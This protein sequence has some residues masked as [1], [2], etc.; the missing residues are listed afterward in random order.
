MGAGWKQWVTVGL[1]CAM[2]QTALGA[3]DDSAC[4]SLLH[5][6]RFGTPH[7][8][9]IGMAQLATTV[10]A[11]DS[12]RALILDAVR[13]AA[14]ARVEL[15]IFPELV[16]SGY[17]PRDWV[18]RPEFIQKNQ[19]SLDAIAAEVAAIPHAPQVLYLGSM[20][21][22]P[23]PQGRALQ[24]SAVRLAAGRIADIQAKSL[25]PTMD[26]FDE[27]RHFE[28]GSG[29]HL[30]QMASDVQL[31]C[32]ICEDA[33][34][35]PANGERS[36]YQRDLARELEQA[37]LIVNLSASPFFRGKVTLRDQVVGG[38]AARAHA[39]LVYVNAI[40]VH[41][42]L[43]FDG[44]SSLYSRSGEVLLR[45][46]GFEDGL[47]IVDLEIG[48]SSDRIHSAKWIPTRGQSRVLLPGQFIASD[49]EIERIR[50]GLVLSV[51]EYFR[52][53][54]F[55][56]AVLGL[57]GGIDSS[58]VATLLVEALGKDNVLGLL[59]PSR[60][61]SE[62]SI[63]DALALAQ[64]LQIQT[65]TIPIQ[66]PV[67]AVWSALQPAMGKLSWEPALEEASEDNVQ[68]R[69]RGMYI[70][71]FANRY[72]ML[73]VTTSNKSELAVGQC[74]LY[75]DMAGA[76]GVIADLFKTEVYDLARHLN[77]QR[78]RIPVASIEKAPSAELAPGQS[79]E[80]KF[81]AFSVLDPVLRAFLEEGLSIDAIAARG[82]DREYVSKTIA[83]VRANE[84]KRR[85]I[86]I[87]PKVSPK[88]FGPGR[89]IPIAA[90]PSSGGER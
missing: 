28:P 25:L 46:P 15:L 75:G 9:H 4:V 89:R 80:A 68:A 23:A 29:V 54:G 36:L 30:A 56:K 51:R 17:P 5:R 79:D 19:A 74:T 85:Q 8:L 87:I 16:V 72:G 35:V 18:E 11:F 81:G 43:I 71:A 33:W 88:A 47:A 45:L 55:K 42:D 66:A 78:Q 49:S 31:G 86:T 50:K 44:H 90:D 59:M 84:Y 13:K 70:M 1:F 69:M 60:Y 24:N 2:A 53:T 63:T 10:G 62:G 58:V 73:A 39:P 57:S 37:E 26:V 64:A 77:S 6:A 12:N 83:I 21:R 61:N 65:L 52:K 40:G 76:I 34:S 7:R 82:F 32:L 14:E 41:D 67:D 20:T 3:T 22:N 38:F 27:A 48:T